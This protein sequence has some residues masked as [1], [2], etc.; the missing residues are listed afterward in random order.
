MHVTTSAAHDAAVA[1]LDGRL[2]L[3]SAPGLRLQGAAAL[4]SARGRLVLDLG[5]VT[6]I[7]SSGLGVLVGLHRE[8]ARLG[9]SLTIVPPSGSARQIFALTRT[10]SFFHLVESLEAARVAA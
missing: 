7:D 5:A 8:A 10:E 3:R 4:A 6:F 9:G 1:T 2:D